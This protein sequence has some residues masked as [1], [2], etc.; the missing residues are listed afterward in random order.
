MWL[1]LFSATII[2]LAVPVVVGAFV[3]V[4]QNLVGCRHL[5]KGSTIAPR[6]VGMG[7][8]GPSTVGLLNFSRVGT[9][10]GQP[11]NVVV[12]VVL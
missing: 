10:L 6:L 5:V 4:R 11:E 9:A 7:L 8:D 3:I 1:L 2:I 12:V